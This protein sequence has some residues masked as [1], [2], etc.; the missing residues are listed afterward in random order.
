MHLSHIVICIGGQISWKRA[1]ILVINIPIPELAFHTI[2]RNNHPILY[3]HKRM[4]HRILRRQSDS[5][6]YFMASVVL[7]IWW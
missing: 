5:N 6:A 4:M 2:L 1:D 7:A 3:H